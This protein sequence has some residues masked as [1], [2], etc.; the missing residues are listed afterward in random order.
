M[1]VAMFAMGLLVMAPAVAKVENVCEAPQKTT[2]E[3]DIESE[4][5]AALEEV[6]AD[7]IDLSGSTI[8]QAPVEEQSCPQTISAPEGG[9]A[10]NECKAPQDTTNKGDIEDKPKV[11]LQDAVIDDLSV[12]GSTIEQT[13]ALEQ[14]CPQT[15]GIQ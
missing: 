13:P 7:D 4:I 14:S 8:L 3:G 11:D 10:K 9:D 2:N 15:I 6:T 5:K 12:S 1:L